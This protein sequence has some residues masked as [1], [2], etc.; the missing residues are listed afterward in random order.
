MKHHVESQQVTM[1]IPDP[2]QLLILN[3]A[4]EAERKAPPSGIRTFYSRHVKRVLDI[5]FVL[6][7]APFVLPVVLL[8]AAIIARDGG[9]PFYSQLRVGR[10]GRSF[11][12]WKLRSMVHNAD[13]QLEE[14]LVHNPLAR[15][16]WDLSQKLKNDPRITKSGHFL[17]KS[18]LDELPQ[19]WNVLKGDMS[20]VG[21]RPMLLEQ[22]QLYPGAD[23]YHL[24]PGVTG[25]W[26]ISD[27]ND[28]SFAAR[29]TYDAQYAARLSFRFD[30]RIIF[31]TAGVV[32]RGTGY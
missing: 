16:E 12:L 21:P 28:S 31:K 9:S 17:R 27:R 2:V 5:L 25:L 23:Y 18:S 1:T 10:S 20:I 24:R 32:L 11:R 29:A 19:L 7:V 15:A 26:Q 6:C 30:M 22:A 4:A 13:A 14:Y 3:Y 8:L